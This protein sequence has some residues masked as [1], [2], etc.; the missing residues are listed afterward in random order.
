MGVGDVN[1]DG[2]N[3]IGVAWNDP[4][5]GG[6]FDIVDGTGFVVAVS[7]TYIAR[8]TT[9]HNGGFTSGA[10]GD[11]D[12]DGTEDLVLGAKLADPGG[13]QNA[14]MAFVLMGPHP[15]GPTDAALAGGPTFQGHQEDMVGATVGLGDVT[16]DG[17]KDVLVGFSQSDLPGPGGV[18]VFHA[19]VASIALSPE[20]ADAEIVGAAPDASAS[21]LDIGASGNGDA[22]RDLLVGSPSMDSDG[23]GAHILFGTGL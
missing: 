5:S 3:D 10:V 23:G 14:G 13:L 2:V 20:D 19:P 18:L 15:L 8:Y 7:T 11:V 16:G 4:V 17:Q 22:T 6:F 21:A 1:G 12:G 9:T